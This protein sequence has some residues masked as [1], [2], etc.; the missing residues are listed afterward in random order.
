MS[1]REAW[2][3]AA[4]GVINTLP[5]LPA[6]LGTMFP[7]IS[8]KALRPPYTVSS[9]TDTSTGRLGYISLSNSAHICSDSETWVSAS[10][11]GPMAYP[12]ICFDRP[13]A[14]S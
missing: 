3:F 5:A 11:I 8:Q 12:P 10:M 2:D 4:E 13:L 6:G 7:S 9:G 1:V 14:S